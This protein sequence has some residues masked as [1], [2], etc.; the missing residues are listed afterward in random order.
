MFGH[1]RSFC[2]LLLLAGAMLLWSAGP[3]FAR[4]GGHGGGHGGGF[5]G[6]GFHAGGIHAGGFHAGGFHT[7]G[8]HAGGFHGGVFNRGYYGGYGY[9]RPYYFGGGYYGGFGG[10]GGYG[11]PFLGGY[12][13]PYYNSYYYP[14]YSNNYYPNYSSSYLYAPYYSTGGYPYTNGTI[15][16]LSA[17]QAAPAVPPVPQNQ[18]ALVHVQVPPNAEV[19]FS[20]EKTNST[21]T[22]RDFQSPPLTPGSRYAYDIRARWQQDGQEVTQEQTVTVWAGAN[23]TVTFPRPEAPPQQP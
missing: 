18:T 9:H 8:F 6:G 5:H 22:V 17:Q 14:Y 7:G 11:Y 10:Y 23:V 13:Y 19:W 16:T 12:S 21:G 3:S 20:G 1:T 4:G 15:T 2:G